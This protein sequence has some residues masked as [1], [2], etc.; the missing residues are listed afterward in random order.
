[1]NCRLVGLYTKTR[2]FVEDILESLV[3]AS[4][5]DYIADRVFKGRIKSHDDGWGCA[6]ALMKNS[7]WRIVFYKTVK[8]IWKDGISFLKKS[9][10]NFHQVI[11]VIHTRKASSNTPIDTFSSH[12]FHVVVADGSS[13]YLVQ[14][15][16]LNKKGAWEVICEE[17]D[18]E[19]DDVSDTFMYS[20]MLAKYYKLGSG[21]PPERLA[22]TL[23]KLHFFLEA[24]DLAGRCVNT[25]LLQ[26][27][28][29]DKVALG[30]VVYYTQEKYREYYEVYEITTEDG[31][32]AYVSS[33]VAEEL[34]KKGYSVKLVENRKIIVHFL[35]DGVLRKISYDLKSI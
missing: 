26:Y 29:R 10:E 5:Y 6:L 18:F 14:N 3:T 7:A 31:E 4:K 28:P 22:K 21:A 27:A 9:L 13:L 8:P 11:G 32:I 2:Q 17:C 33:T 24:E 35:E 1:M 12:P 30:I 16:G 23:R 25:F 20:L 34:E 15:G 19:P